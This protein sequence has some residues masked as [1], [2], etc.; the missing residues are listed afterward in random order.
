MDQGY[1]FRFVVSGTPKATLDSPNRAKIGKS[2]KDV[3]KL[4]G[5]QGRGA[6]PNNAVT[7]LERA[8][9]EISRDGR[10][11]VPRVQRLCSD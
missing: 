9:G 6:W 11:G 7:Q 3:E 2:L 10:A 1:Y 4:L 8:L 5:G